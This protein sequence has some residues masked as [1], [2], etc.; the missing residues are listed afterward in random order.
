[1][2]RPTAEPR[3]AAVMRGAALGA[4]LLA[5]AAIRLHR[6]DA[7]SFWFDEANE[8]GIA[9]GSLPRIV[10]RLRDDANPPLHSFLL[11]AW[12]GIFGSSETALRGMSVVASLAMIVGIHRAGALALS[13]AAG[14]WGALAAAFAPAQIFQSQQSRMYT[15][16]PALAVASFIA[17]VRFIHEK[18]AAHLALYVV[19][20]ALAL[21]THNFAFHL[22]PAQALVVAASGTLR[23]RWRSWLAAAA[24]IALLY[25]PWAP[26][27]WKQLSGGDAYSWFSAVWAS[28]PP[29]FPAWA[30]LRSLGF[31]GSHVA[32]DD[33][34]TAVAFDA[35]TV[36][37]LA[38]ALF[39]L[40][41]LRKRGR[42]L[43]A[44]WVPAAAFA[45]IATGIVA[46][47]LLAPH[48]V[49]GRVDQM[50][51]P[52]YAVLIGAGIA[53]LPRLWMRAIV[54]I[55]IA[56]AGLAAFAGY[57]PNYQTPPFRGADRELAA[58]L[59]ERMGPNDHLLCTSLSRATLDYYLRDTGIPARTESF[60]RAV[61]QNMGGQGDAVVAERMESWYRDLETWLG[62][63]RAEAPPGA[64]LFAVIVDDRI[65]K[66]LVGFLGSGKVVG[67]SEEIGFFR[68][69]GLGKSMYV[70][71]CPLR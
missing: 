10:E 27:F 44:V 66:P 68:Q 63:L 61:V 64:A 65:N 4:I 24:A 15:L 48:F 9:R 35:P 47:H 14:L 31:T 58:T 23:A 30:S 38:L 54:G 5:A 53:G 7:L 29:W 50:C 43:A 37:A 18:R 20:T 32:F 69:C 56:A 1:M 40:V 51:Y 26:A 36:A 59:R 62:S 2:T 6:I 41:V 28:W 11:H 13:P 45:P 8:Y 70:V 25:A 17:L 55:A 21:L 57:Y 42:P 52:A 39:G 22:L 16:L 67:R 71:R 49:P 19:S 33:L 60:P 12:M 3:R 46:S 34:R